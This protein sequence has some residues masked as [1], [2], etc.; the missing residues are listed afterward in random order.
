M[1]SR[2]WKF[3]GQLSLVFFSIVG[4]GLISAG[5]YMFGFYKGYTHYVREFLGGLSQAGS[6]QQPPPETY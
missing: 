4:V 6:S 3:V 1:S 2:A 5:I